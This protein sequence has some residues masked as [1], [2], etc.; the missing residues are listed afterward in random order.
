MAYRALA[1][2]LVL[3]HGAFIVFVVF[4]ALLALRFPRLA[5]IHVPCALW[6]VLIEAT[7]W[8][9]PLTPLEIHFR[10]LAGSA[11]YSG[12]F[13]EHYLVPTIY[14]TGLTN[15]AQWWLAA[16]LLCVNACLYALLWRNHRASARG[17]RSASI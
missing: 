1:D 15:T 13:I 14:P 7:G 2:L 5:W 17:I 16:A 10:R 4:G 6:G 11:G 3:L 8:I 9:C 12:G